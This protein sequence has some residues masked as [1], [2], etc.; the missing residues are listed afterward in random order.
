MLAII[1]AL[2]DW[3][4]FLEGLPEPFEII[5]D[6]QNLEFWRTAQDLSQRQAR[7]ALWLSWFDFRLKHCPGKANTQADALSRMS[8]HQINDSEDNQEQ[9]VLRPEHFIHAS[10]MVL[11]HNPL[12]DQIRLASE[13]EAEVLEG[14]K[15]IKGPQSLTSGLAEWR[16]E[17]GIVYHREKVY[18]PPDQG[19]RRAVLEQCHDALTAG[20]PGVHGTLELVDRQFG[21]QECGP[22]WTNM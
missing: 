19:L 6:H 9:T 21:G 13:R 3:R 20:H 12:F 22:L 11:F 4:S 8:H 17:N 14:L 16:E 10:T 5:T 15:K 7:W 1:E 2:K 18:V